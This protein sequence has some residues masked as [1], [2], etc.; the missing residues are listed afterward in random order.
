MTAWVEVVNTSRAGERVARVRWCESFLCRTRG[1]MFRRQIDA[2][3]GLLLVE[4]KASR[5]GTSIH[6]F[7]V[8]MPLGVAWLDPAWRVVS[9]TVAQPWR[10]Y[11]PDQPARFVLEGRPDMLESLAVGDL[12]KATNLESHA[13]V[14]S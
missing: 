12:L 7:F 14:S 3:S 6:M 11:W 5:S 1:L 2:G 13:P 8:F 10:L 4:P 9:T